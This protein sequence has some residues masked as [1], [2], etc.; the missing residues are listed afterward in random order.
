MLFYA[1]ES[2]TCEYNCLE[3]EYIAS[4]DTSTKN[5]SAGTLLRV[6]SSRESKNVR[7]YFL[8]SRSRTRIFPQGTRE[9]V[10]CTRVLA[11]NSHARLFYVLAN[12]VHGMQNSFS[13]DMKENIRRTCIHVFLK[14]HHFAITYSRKDISFYT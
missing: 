12:N 4:P 5:A 14:C 1:C 3:Y 7:K 10:L 13:I 9:S 2:T 11:R 8:E 6:H